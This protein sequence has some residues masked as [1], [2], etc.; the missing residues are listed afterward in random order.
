MNL[1]INNEKKF[2][3]ELCV[4]KTKD[5]S[6]L[7]QHVKMVHLKIKGFAC[8]SCKYVCSLNSHLNKHIRNKHSNIKEFECNL[9]K[10]VCSLNSNLERHIK[11]KHTHIKKFEC[12]Q[13]KEFFFTNDSLKNHIKSIHEMPQELK[14]ISL[15]EYKIFRIL[16]NFKVKFKREFI[17]QNLLSKKG[18]SLRFDFGIYNPTQQNYLLI[19]F[20]GKPHF[21]KVKWSN[22]DTEQQIKEKFEYIQFC[23]NQKNEYVKD[24][25]HHLLRIKYDDKDIE[26]K[27][28]EFLL[29]NQIK[30]RL[31]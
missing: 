29:S 2:K 17:F 20:D 22:T 15:G 16:N 8:N 31:E 30:L 21:Q 27:I 14:R 3:C 18:R 4:Y 26:I 24:N 19:E 28:L 5:K 13:C 25:N 12:S 23:D 7:N 9:C 11:Y 10:Y 1:N 6:N